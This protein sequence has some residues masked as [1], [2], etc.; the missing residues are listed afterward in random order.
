MFLTSSRIYVPNTPRKHTSVSE[1][2][3]ECINTAKLYNSVRQ[4][5]DCRIKKKLTVQGGAGRV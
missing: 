4:K 3:Q 2:R 1:E 5:L